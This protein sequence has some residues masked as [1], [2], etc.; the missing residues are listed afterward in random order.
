MLIK[1]EQAGEGF[2]VGEGAGVPVV[3]P[4]VGG[5]HGC[6]I[7]WLGGTLPFSPEGVVA[8]MWWKIRDDGLQAV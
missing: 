2:G 3:G 6:S 5:G 4:A 8:R 7:G 1:S